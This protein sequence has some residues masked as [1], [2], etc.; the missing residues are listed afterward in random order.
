MSVVLPDRWLRLIPTTAERG[1]R[2]VRGE[3]AY[4]WDEDDKRY[5]DLDSGR[6]ANLLG[7]GQPDVVEAIRRQ[8]QRPT[9][10]HH[11]FEHDARDEFVEALSLVTPETLTDV[12]MVNSGFEALDAAITAA[13]LVTRRTRVISTDG[14]PRVRTTKGRVIAERSKPEPARRNGGA[15]VRVPFGD[16]DA[17]DEALDGDTAAVVVEPM[18]ADAGV[19]IP[20]DGYIGGVSQRARQAGALLIVDEVQ[21]ALRTGTTLLS[22]QQRVVPDILCMARGLANGLPIGVVVTQHGIGR[23]LRLRSGWYDATEAGNPIVCAAATATLRIAAN[24]TLQAHVST[25]G[26]HFINRLRALRIQEIREVRGRGF[27]VALELRHG[28][29]PI[30]RQLQERGII[31]ILG[32]D[33][34]IRLLPPLILDRRQVDHVVETIPLA[35]RAARRAGQYPETRSREVSLRGVAARPRARS[36]IS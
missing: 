19:L 14:I 10:S 11:A 21:T 28:A 7:Y 15:L 25:L 18:L 30:V 1:M 27:M 29:A 3:G 2:V 12:V 9:A 24:P 17:L 4:V 16:L 22:R 5:L 33:G 35:I 20:H 23:K 31:A 26:E 8:L 6:G 32:L 36:P 13:R 34:V